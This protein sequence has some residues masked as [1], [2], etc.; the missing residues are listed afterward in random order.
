MKQQDIDQ[1][2]QERQEYKEGRSNVT[3][4]QKQIQ[5]LRCQLKERTS[6]LGVTIP[7]DIYARNR[8][9]VSQVTGVTQGYSGSTIMGG[10]NEQSQAR[11]PHWRTSQFSLPTT[12]RKIGQAIQIT[13]KE[14]A[15][16]V[17]NNECGTNADTC[18]LGKNYV[19]LNN[20]SRTANVYAY[21]TSIKPLEGVP[22]IS[23][24]TAYDYLGTNMAYILVVNE[25]LYYGNK[26]DHSLINP[27]QV[28]AYGIYFWENPFDRQIGFTIALKDEVTNLMQAMGTKILYKTRMATEI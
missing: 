1:L 19:I 5:E 26:L 12:D 27:N 22:I 11:D 24:A 23:G 3:N 2:T 8:N 16:T 15:G 6:Q 4:T 10:R 13:K 17:A 9:Q 28:R 18:W 25:A 14:P 20:A 7:E 21:D